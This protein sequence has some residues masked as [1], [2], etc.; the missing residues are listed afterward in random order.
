MAMDAAWIA[1][2]GT[3]GGVALTALASLQSARLTVNSQRA[4]AQRLHDAHEK[5]R[6]ERR[7]AFVTYLSAYQA[8]NSRAVE[9]I[10]GPSAHDVVGRFGDKE[11]N[12]FSRAYQELLIMAERPE[13]VEAARVA[14][15][16]LWE[17]VEAVPSG[18]EAFRE[19]EQRAQAPRRR[20][21]AEM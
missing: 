17:M 18:V 7:A 3:L 13:T 12:A 19:A 11:S 21:R 20:F 14:T 5:L 15:A 16:A 9:K 4:A 2:I 6:D 8:L 1:V 10:E